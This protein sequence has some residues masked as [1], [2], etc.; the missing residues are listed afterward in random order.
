M[1]SAPIPANESERQAALDSYKILNSTEES[2]YDELTQL[3]SH[4]CGTK[5]SLISLIDQNRQ[6]FKSHHG[7]DARETPRDVAF[8]A[9][10]VAEKK[11]LIVRDSRND[12]RFADNPLVTGG[13][14]VVFYAGVP[15]IDAEGYA[16]G[17]LCVIDHAPRDLAEHQIRA[18]QTLANQVISQFRLRRELDQK[19]LITARMANISANI[20]GVIYQACLKQ[21]GG[22]QFPYV[23]EAVNEIYELS[24]EDVMASPVQIFTRT[25]PDDREALIESVQLSAQTMQTW[26]HEYRIVTPKKGLRWV[27]GT[28]RPERQTDGSILWHGFLKDVTEQNSLNTRI[29]QSAKMVALGEMAAGFAHEINNPLAI[30]MGK[31]AILRKLV[32]R[33]PVDTKRLGTEILKIDAMAERIGKIIKGLRTFSRDTGNDL[34]STARLATIV[35]ETIPLV[36]ERLSSDGIDLT[37]DVALDIDLICNPTQIAQV[38]VNLVNNARD[39]ILSSGSTERWIRIDTSVQDGRVALSISDS[40]PGVSPDN[41]AKIMQP[42]FTTKA[43]GEGTGLGLSISKK[44]IERH[45]GQL[46]LKSGTAHTMFVIE[47]PRPQP[48]QKIAAA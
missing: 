48:T 13:P 32:D 15:L 23:S 26:T 44:L 40:G 17:T 45:G 18:L 43:A 9:H 4:L 22:V 1:K 47:L 10:A 27:H 38:L 20:P 37:V 30:I 28:A 39:A 42:F 29:A 2:C 33:D 8:C 16:L 6:W 12:S 34:M 5:I 31:T 3:A 35:E 7:L 36:H 19:R 24:P 21:D 11:P 14:N 41:E 25:H 46:Y